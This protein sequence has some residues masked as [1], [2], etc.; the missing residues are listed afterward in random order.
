MNRTLISVWNISIGKTGLPFYFSEVS[1]L[2]EV[3]TRTTQKVIFHLL[4]DR[5]FRKSFVNGKHPASPNILQDFSLHRKVPRT[6]F[7]CALHIEPVLI[8]HEVFWP[9]LFCSGVQLADVQTNFDVETLASDILLTPQGTF[10]RES[11][12]NRFKRVASEVHSIFR[13][14]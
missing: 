12:L 10:G 9:G 3:S 14:H 11:S 5:N 13:I 2:P 7:Y 4:S 1:F 8:W 6:S